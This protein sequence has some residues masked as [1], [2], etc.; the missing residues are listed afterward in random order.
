MKNS[1]AGRAPYEIRLQLTLS[2][3]LLQHLR[4]YLKNDR[5]FADR[6]HVAIQLARASRDGFEFAPRHTGSL[7]HFF[8]LLR[9]RDPARQDRYP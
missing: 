8:P 4:V 3:R 2:D 9:H 6:V 7:G 5:Q 1:V